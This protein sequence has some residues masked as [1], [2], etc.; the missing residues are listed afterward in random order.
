MTALYSV[1]IH[2]A[3]GSATTLADYRGKVLLIVNVASECG[4]TPQY[5][6]LEAIYERYRERGFVVLGFPCNDF[7]AQEPGTADQIQTFC[8]TTYG[9]EFPVFSKISVTRQN[10]Y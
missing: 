2:R 6:A 4:L 1:P 7:G 3:D 10:R 5:T 9:V 8:R